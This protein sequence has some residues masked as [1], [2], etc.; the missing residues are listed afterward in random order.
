MIKQTFSLGAIMSKLGLFSHLCVDLS[1]YVPPNH[2]TP[3]SR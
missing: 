2:L 1:K 3:Y